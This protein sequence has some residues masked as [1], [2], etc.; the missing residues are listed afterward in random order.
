MK[1]RI[2]IS[3]AKAAAYLEAGLEVE[4]H[5]IVE[6]EAAAV[7][8]V[9]APGKRHKRS[10]ITRDETIYRLA[11]KAPSYSPGSDCSVALEQLMN[12]FKGGAKRRTRSQIDGYL[13]QHLAWSHRKNT[14]T[15]ANL[16]R[17]GYLV[18]EKI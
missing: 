3:L 18:L 9:E 16:R 15:I 4:C 17:D 13:T 14:S 11:G 12:L 8:V 2:K 5:L 7:P 6:G 10:F 1:T